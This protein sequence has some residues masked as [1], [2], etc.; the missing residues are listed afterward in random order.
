MSG[1]FRGYVPIQL[2]KPR[3]L[4]FDWAAIAEFEEVT[5]KPFHL[6]FGKDGKD[7]GVSLMRK[8]LWAGLI[9]EDPTLLSDPLEGIRRVGHWM[10][11]VPGDS[12]EERFS[13]IGSKVME[14]ANLYFGEGDSKKKNPPQETEPG[15][16]A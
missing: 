1:R 15:K 14:A 6:S 13:Y 10:D 12:A 7:I 9:H 5:G 8:M 4:H 16:E 11:L 2:D 3:Q